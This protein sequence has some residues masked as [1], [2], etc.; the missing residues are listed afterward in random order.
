MASKARRHATADPIALSG[1]QASGAPVR[2]AAQNAE[3]SWRYAASR[4]PPWQ[5]RCGS[6]GGIGHPAFRRLEHRSSRRG[7][8]LDAV[9][10]ALPPSSNRNASA[11]PLSS[12]VPLVP[13]NTS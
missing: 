2:T 9:G 10:R 12:S 6:A 7:G 11:S 1:P 5:W 3:I 8:D 4:S 13:K